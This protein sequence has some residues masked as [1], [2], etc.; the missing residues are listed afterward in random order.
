MERMI[1]RIFRGAPEHW[2]GDGFRVNNT[3]VGMYGVAPVARAGAIAAPSGGV[4]VDAEARTA[5]NSIR[6]ALTNIG[7]TS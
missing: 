4:T 6:T 3:G 7:L 2:V 5:I 1:E